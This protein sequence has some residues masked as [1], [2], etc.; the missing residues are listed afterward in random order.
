[1]MGKFFKWVGIICAVLIGL[2]VLGS[3]VGEEEGA[4]SSSSNSS[5]TG[6][7][8]SS[9]TATR[10]SRTEG[11]IGNRFDGRL[12]AAQVD[13][14][15]IAERVGIQFME[16][17]AARGAVFV[18]VRFSYSNISDG[19]IGS[20]RRPDV[21]LVSGG[22]AEFSEDT[23]ASAMFAAQAEIDENAFSNLNP[24]IEYDGAAV[25]EIAESMLSDEGWA[26]KVELD[27]GTFYVPFSVQ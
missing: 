13:G 8:G 11:A 22:G 3:M 4:T 9:S 12:V 18:V 27:R 6:Q 25:F 24:G 5:A 20:F 19:P 23:G 17:T 16:E 21:R 7:S 2:A 26:V 1:M 14:I 10:P 15:S